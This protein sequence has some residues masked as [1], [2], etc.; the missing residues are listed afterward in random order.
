M[1]TAGPVSTEG[2]NATK[3]AETLRMASVETTSSALKGAIQL[4][5]AHTVGS[6]SQ[7]PERDVLMQ[8]FEVVE[9][10][11]FPS[12]GSN[13]T[14]AHHHGDFRFKTYAPIAF[15]YFREMFG[16]R[17]DDYLYSLCNDPLIELSNPGASGSVFYVSSDDEFIIKTVQ[18]K[19]AEFL[20]KLL[21]G[22]F[23]NLNQNKRTL[24]PKF[25]GLYCIQAGGKNIRIVVMNNLLPRAVPMH[26]KYDLKGST[27]KRRASSTERMKSL[28]TYKDLDFIQDLPDGLMLENDHYNA[29]CKTIQR[30]CLLLQSFKIMDYSLL[31]GIHN[32]DQ[33]GK[34]VAMAVA[35]AV[36]DPK[37]NQGQ[38]PLY[39]TTMEAIQGEA[40]GKAAPQCSERFDTLPGMGGIPAHNLKGE[41]LLMFIGIIDILQSYSVDNSEYMRNGD[42]LPTRL[43][44]QQD[45]VNIVCHSKTRSNPE[46]NVGL[47][48]MANNCEVLTTLTPDTGR[49]LSKLH[50]VQPRGKISFCTGI[51]VAHL[52]LK[53]R[54]GKNHK[55]R[56]IAFVGSPVE[57]NEKDLLKLAKRLKKEKVNVD[58]IN[59]GEEE[60]NTE[61]LTVF[62]NTLN[63]KE[64]TGSHLVT[65]PPG[66]SLADALLSSPILAGEGG[67]MM[68]LG[69]SDFEF[70]VDP[71]ADPELAL[72]LRV[73]MEEQRQRQEEEA[74][75]AAAQ[76][77][78]EA[79]IATPTADE[80]EE[81]LLKMSVSQPETGVTSL[82][83]FSSMTEEEQI[84][85][86]MQMSLAGGEFGESMEME[87]PIGTAES[88]KEEDDYDVMQDPEFLQSVLEN[89]P[90][91][92]PNNE[93]IRNAMGSLA[94]QSGTKPDNKKDEEKK[95]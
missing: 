23:M 65:V 40:K 62:V 18:H 66:P 77:A 80:S 86:A 92:D 10:I 87:A 5:I 76:S 24:L 11:F 58:V 51:R 41:R 1:A 20:Q 93:A 14:P 33:S 30:D 17:S 15:R 64:G 63:G 67:T 4:G 71:S 57:D 94:S 35:M 81:A 91:V 59:F 49:I 90:G 42:F 78:A 73:S 7:K 56:I 68:G 2:M 72:A 45:A 83:D 53:H 88:A 25:Y 22:Y 26:L 6:L 43:Q 54:Q 32:V 84:A 8:D 3:P 61:K 29:L 36:P 38:K 48:T 19:E 27:Y 74:R 85:Y 47:I 34:E 70:G 69:A 16:I 89:L 13:L 28:P 82:P 95:K 75:R 50:A 37:K 21:P 44:A 52:A 39:C 46:N 12:E 55:M 79:G 31:V 9:S 60:V